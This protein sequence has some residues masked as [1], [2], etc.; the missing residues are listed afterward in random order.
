MI[1]L[2]CLS[3][4][5]TRA[6][7]VIVVYPGIFCVLV[8]YV[9]CY[10]IYWYVEYRPS[11]RPRTLCTMLWIKLGHHVLSHT[12]YLDMR[13]VTILGPNIE[14]CQI[15]ITSGQANVRSLDAVHLVVPVISSLIIK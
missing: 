5:P 12:I 4:G 10:I 7:T 15:F 2:Y 11:F 13:A 1:L 3:I 9:L 8:Y 6:H 14:T